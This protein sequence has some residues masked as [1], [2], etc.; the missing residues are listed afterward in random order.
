MPTHVTPFTVLALL[1]QVAARARLDAEAQ[2]RLATDIARIEAAHFSR[3]AD[4]SLDLQAVATAWLR[5]AS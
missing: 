1:Q 5:T 3:A 4:P 2:Q